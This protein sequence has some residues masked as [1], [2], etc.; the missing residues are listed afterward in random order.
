MI[1]AISA[2][3]VE[4]ALILGMKLMKQEGKQRDSRNGPVLR[5]DGTVVTEYRKPN[6]RVVFNAERDANP[7]FHLMESLWMLGGSN[8]VE[9]ISRF[10]SGMSNY[11]DDGVTFHGAYGYRWR[12]HFPVG[13]FGDSLDQLSTIAS[14]LKTNKDD[15]RA[16]LQMWDASCDLGF[17]G[18]DFPCNI[19]AVFSRS[20]SGNLDMTVYNRSND[21]IWGAYGANAVHFS[22]MQEVMAAWIGIPMGSY[23]QVSANFHAYVNTMEK[24]ISIC[25]LFPDAS[26]YEIGRV[27]SSPIVNGSIDSWFQDLDI[28]LT[29][30]PTIGF[31]DQFF[32]KTVVPMQL[33]WDAWKS[34][35]GDYIQ[36]AIHKANQI[37]SED[38]RVACVEWLERKIK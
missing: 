19:A 33:S 21:M 36:M 29:Q 28:F 35:E 10:N 20:V 34:K 6:E 18:K 38:W 32:K 22:V 15:R 9:W 17:A 16:V 14:I 1:H 2:R 26:Y 7:F 31:Q 23:F 12:E 27:V 5:L 37:A 25:D 11:S 13:S 30:G 8:D 24:H 4:E 3:N